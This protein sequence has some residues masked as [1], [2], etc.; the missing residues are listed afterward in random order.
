MLIAASLYWIIPAFLAWSCL[1]HGQRPAGQF[2]AV[3]PVDGS[4]RLRTRWH[5]YKPKPPRIASVLVF[6]DGDAIH[7]TERL[8]CCPQV[9]LS[10]LAGQSADEYVHTVTLRSIGRNRCQAFQ[11]G[12]Y[13][14]QDL[15][16]T[17]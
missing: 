11:L 5:F 4:L 6:D 3:K 12:V 2:C 8:K 1:V 7:V 17:A 10:Q 13:W 14:G 15:A 9:R 16:T